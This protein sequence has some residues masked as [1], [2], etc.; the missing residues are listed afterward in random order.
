VITTLNPLFEMDIYLPRSIVA[1][2][3]VFE[4]NVVLKESWVPIEVACA[5]ILYWMKKTRARNVFI[6]SPY[7]TEEEKVILQ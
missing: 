5:A 7:V 3:N 1:S 4:L 2:L 6:S